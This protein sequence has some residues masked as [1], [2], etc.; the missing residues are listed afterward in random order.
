MSLLIQVRF[1][2]DAFRRG[3]IRTGAAN[4]SEPAHLDRRRPEVS[5]HFIVRDIVRLKTQTGFVDPDPSWW[6]HLVSVVLS[7]L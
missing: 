5:I 4:G 6:S 2:G 1:H 3:W 7:E